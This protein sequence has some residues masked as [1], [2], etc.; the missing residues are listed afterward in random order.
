M[1]KRQDE[2]VK[3]DVIGYIVPWT[4]LEW[5]V[6]ENAW[7]NT[8][9]ARKA[10]LRMAMNCQLYWNFAIL[11][12]NHIS[13]FL[14]NMSFYLS[15]CCF[16]ITRCFF[17]SLFWQ[18]ILIELQHAIKANQSWKIK[19]ILIAEMT[20][21]LLKWYGVPKQILSSHMKLNHPPCS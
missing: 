8:H 16:E 14:R 1:N 9:I 5:Q 19:S 18:N 21:C 2:C 7:Q 15:L 3:G 4:F 20:R 6:I 17:Q 12:W 10:N 13:S 11:H